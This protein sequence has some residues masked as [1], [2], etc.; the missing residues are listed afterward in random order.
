MGSTEL[1]SMLE[2]NVPVMLNW[3]HTSENHSAPDVMSHW[4]IW[5]QKGSQYKEKT[6]EKE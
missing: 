1:S 3:L 5:T 6:T 2:H 4:N